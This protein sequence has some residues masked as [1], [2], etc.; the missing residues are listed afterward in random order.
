M[1]I[2][3]FAL[4][5]HQFSTIIV[6][7]LVLIGI[8]SFMTMPRSEDPQISP[9]GTTIFVVYPGANPVDIEKLV[10]QPIE[11]VLNELDDIKELKSLSRTG[12]GQ[13]DI[14]FISGSDGD[15]K[16]S[17]VVQKVNSI[18]NTLPDEVLNVEMMK[19]T[20][21]D[22]KILQYAL[23]SE[24]S[25]YAQLEKEA[26]TL[27]DLLKTTTGIK[28][29]ETWAYPEQEVRVTINME[30]LANMNIGLNQLIGSIQ[31]SSINIPGGKLDMGGRQFNIQTSGSFE[32]IDDVKNIIVNTGL[33]TP[34]YLKDIADVFF[35]YEDPSHIARFNGERSVFVTASQKS[36]TNIF[37]VTD[38]LKEKAETFRKSLPPGIRFET[39]FDQSESVSNRLSGFFLN[40]LQGLILVGIIVILA[41]GSRASI[42]VMLVIPISILIGIGLLDLS[43]YGL[44]QMSIAGL[45][46]ALGLL[47]DNAIVVTEN[48]A[49]F[50][51]LGYS[52]F[53]SALKGT[54]QI[55]W[56][57][58]SSTLTT[59]LAFVP[60]ML[61]ADI[62]G[63]F[64]RSM[65]LT[66]VF[67]LLA[68]L[69]VSLTITPYLS[70]RFMRGKEEQRESKLRQQLNK[71][72]NGRYRRTL[73]YALNRPKLVIIIS[74]IIFALS[75]SLFP[76]IGVSFFPKAEKPQFI[77]NVNLPEGS[78]IDRTDEVAAHI[79]SVLNKKSEILN[80]ATNVGRG[81]PRIYYNVLSKRNANNHAQFLIE[82]EEYQFEKFNRLLDELRNEF[83]DFPGAQIEV[84]DFIQGPPVE[85]P[86]AIKIV[87]DN[88][89][90]LKE[91]SLSV[92]EIF[93]GTEGTLNISN[94]LSTT[95]S[96][97]HVNINREKASMYGVPLVEIDRAVRAQINGIIV[98]NFRDDQGKEFNIVVRGQNLEDAKLSHF[99]KIYV[100]NIKGVQIP[101]KQI[102]SIEFESTPLE[103]SHYDLTRTVTI[104]SDV[105]T[106]F[107]VND[108]TNEII[109]KL[110]DYNWPKGY[111]F[112]VGGELES[113]QESFGGMAKALIIAIVGIFG[114]L[115]LQFKSYSQ[116]LIVFSAVPLAII[117]SI[118]AL[119]LTG[120]SFSFTAFVGLTS[121]VGIVINNSIILVDYSNQLR[122]EGKSIIEAVKIAGEVRFIPIVLTTATTI[123]GLLPLTL[124]GGT[125][126][127][128]MGW[129][130]IGGLIASTFLTLVVVPV[131]YKVF[132]K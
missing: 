66:V 31:S 35:D 83:N 43:N 100:P 56:A 127:A 113:Q 80:Y 69:W 12:Y 5:N 82:T 29:I 106:D 109:G 132:T 30:R 44:Q 74:I 60:M 70:K 59:I 26:E 45:V 104:T 11:E 23:V 67:T 27:E 14:E 123:G 34:I 102:A 61:M 84:K 54:E 57:V 122:S 114:V 52:K 130:I 41:V 40:L 112:Y 98:S 73:G 62:T 85:A 53:D 96:D 115:V 10:V 129:S 9:A 49:R 81:N 20:I 64:I 93:K 18:R 4:E 120:Y 75:L 8:V 7:I 119:L 65:P 32:S 87:G 128:P 124:G 101:L 86:I 68:S 22:V 111:S 33:S 97:L 37:T 125:M 71:L 94:P 99:D 13:V 42:I 77:I 89:N 38:Q 95:K 90:I 107:L 78:S 91:I 79:E 16:Y 92:E 118:I 17:D 131:L 28:K 108:V 55:A 48:I 39:V 63:E 76:L 105:K 6:A 110:N 24:N 46:I 126:W 121:L 47:V 50:I 3:K 21:N 15:E 117:G 103:I 51:K 72:I 25:S 19:W 1:S 36:G 88:L 116:P 58:S 2:P